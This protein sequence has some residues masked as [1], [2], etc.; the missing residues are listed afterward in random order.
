M[1]RA[2]AAPPS[3]VDVT[4]P[5]TELLAH[6]RL[7]MHEFLP[8]VYELGEFDWWLVK[9]EDRAVLQPSERAY[10]R[11]MDEEFER[12]LQRLLRMLDGYSF[13]EVDVDV[14]RNVYQ[15]YLP[16][17][18]RQRL[19]GFYTPD[20]LVHL[21]LDLADFTP[22]TEGLCELSFID[23][24]CGSGAFA[25]G[26]LARLLKHLELKMSCHKEL[27]K[28]GLPEWK[29]A[30]KILEIAA[31]NL[32][33]IDLHPFAAFL[34]TLNALFLLMPLYVKA[35][36][37][38]P[39]F[40]IDLQ[41]F[42]ADALEKHDAD[43][44]APDL[45]TRAN[46]RIQLTEESLR[47]YNRMM[48]TRFSRVFG[49][50]PWGGVLKGQLAPVYDTLKKRR[51]ADEYRAA[52]GK[53]DVYGLFMERAL[54]ILKPGGCFS[55]VTQGSFLDKEW[56]ADLR[57]TLANDARL[58]FIIDLN[59]FGQLFF[60]AMNIPCITVANAAPRKTK[61]AAKA[62]GD[63]KQEQSGD[64]AEC[65]AILSRQPDDFRSLSVE[66]RR[67][68]VEETIKAVVEKVGGQR[69][70]A[71][72]GF[73]HAA[74]VPLSRL[75]ETARDRWDLTADVSRVA[76]AGWLSAADVLEPF[77]GVTVGGKNC[78]DIF[79][80]FPDE[81]ARRELE[82]ELVHPVI[83][84]HETIRWTMPELHHVIFYPYDVSD[85]AGR[86]AFAI[87]LSEVEDKQM[88][89]ALKRTGIADA[90]DFDHALDAR[91][92]EIARRKGVNRSTV[93]E[94]L[95]HRNTLGLVRYPHAA[96]YLVEH[97]EQ[98]EGRIFKKRN[99]RTFNRRWY[100]YIW[101]R[102][103]KVMFGKLK[104]IAPRLSKEVRFALDARGIV[105]Q[106]SCIAMMPTKKTDRDYRRLHEQLTAATR[107]R[108]MLEDVLKYCLAFLN[109]DYAQ[110]RFVT[111]RRPTPK[112]SYAMS[113]A[114]LREIPIAPPDTQTATT[115]LNLVTQLTRA[116]TE[117]E[118]KKL[119]KKLTQITGALL[120][121]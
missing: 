39:T 12:A 108:A 118:T 89:A 77:Q 16:A 15:H 76:G 23:P 1:E 17:E 28:R 82:K 26:A 62:G 73:A 33:A 45:F 91:E 65:I 49:N 56:A 110:H 20:E 92:G 72:V 52:R 109:S 103:P 114:V 67:A 14:W 104:I 88:Q 19:G 70:S 34:T 75:R 98:L 71:T 115:I 68:C 24:A 9:P 101:P 86:R 79:L 3:I 10:L 107:K 55:L 43:L 61:D 85:D 2:L 31:R 113:E 81:A 106:D 64:E 95:R 8:A 63:E 30:E 46:S 5:A 117:A 25:T 97:Y 100:E 32:H 4:P 119:E 59:P 41:I 74:R 102:A 111:G 40:S 35:R 83:K 105:P 51:F 6:V 13:A 112:G 47:R 37:K 121:T 27:H 44:I 60:K 94:L 120:A 36:A 7:S 96:A 50:P 29:R 48:Q 22:E 87:D 80:M 93:A 78:L 57:E 53:Y 116:K 58:R 42:P 99:I 69:K 54:Q 38:N 11:S 90:L 84:G 21:T 18:E 66:E